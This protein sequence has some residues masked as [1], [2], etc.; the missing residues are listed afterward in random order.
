MLV[1][2]ASL[3]S[4]LVEACGLQL[5]MLRSL[6]H[7]LTWVQGP[8]MPR[9]CSTLCSLLFSLHSLPSIVHLP[10]WSTCHSA[11]YSPPSTLR[12]P[13]QSPFHTLRSPLSTLHSPFTT[14][15]FSSMQLYY[16]PLYSTPCYSS[17][18]YSKLLYSTLHYP[19][20]LVLPSYCFCGF[21]RLLRIS[22]KIL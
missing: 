21:H 2:H 19:T 15:L 13:L 4:C 11:L 5:R 7:A 12:S 20:L 3:T 16:T 14:L 6:G 1:H 9:S 22:L 18:L 10:L 17:Q 8:L